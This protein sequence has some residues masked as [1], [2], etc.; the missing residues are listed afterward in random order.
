MEVSNLQSI[1]DGTQ[2]TQE[3]IST[4]VSTLRTGAKGV[5]G[6]VK[7]AANAAIKQAKV[8]LGLRVSWAKQLIPLMEEQ[9]KLKA[10]IMG[11]ETGLNAARHALDEAQAMLDTANQEFNTIQ[12]IIIQQKKK[13][14]QGGSGPSA[15]EENLFRQAKDNLKRAQDGLDMAKKEVRKFEEDLKE[16]KSDLA[17]IE[18]RI[19]QIKVAMGTTPT[20]TTP[21]D[22]TPSSG[23]LT[24]EEIEQ[25]QTMAQEAR[26]AKE[27]EINAMA[28]GLEKMDA[29]WMVIENGLAV[30]QNLVTPLPQVASLPA[31]VGTGSPNTA[32]NMATAGCVG[33]LAVFVLVEVKAAVVRWSALCEENSVTPT[34]E[35]VAVIQ[36]INGYVA[37]LP[38]ACATGATYVAPVIPQI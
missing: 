4:L 1:I 37:G 22:S 23:I 18:K 9:V 10:I 3:A 34:P 31:F 12:K 25:A 17:A 33:L 2:Q 29:E 16:K 11:Y 36:S 32:F 35:Q 28:P 8:E 19:E 7:D 6:A 27:S 26:T 15:Q 30:I 5:K 24:Q 38:T 20:T 14:L 13:A 21:E